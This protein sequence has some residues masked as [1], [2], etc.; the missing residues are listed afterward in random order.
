M[1]GH[2]SIRQSAQL[3]LTV[4]LQPA[5][6]RGSPTDTTGVRELS[7]GWSPANQ[8]PSRFI[9]PKSARSTQED[10]SSVQRQPGRVESPP[11]RRKQQKG[12]IGGCSHPMLASAAAGCCL[13]PSHAPSPARDCI[14]TLRRAAEGFSFEANIGCEM[15]STIQFF[16]T[17]LRSCGKQRN[18]PRGNGF[19]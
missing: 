18:Y 9:P 19:R 17:R 15:S 11:E 6:F 10:R 2:G 3:R 7:D 4:R 5:G 13:F 12:K 14:S 16:L 1:Y 8:C